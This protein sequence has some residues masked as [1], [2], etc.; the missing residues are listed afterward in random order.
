MVL[1]DSSDKDDAL[2]AVDS[3]DAFGGVASRSNELFLELP[4]KENKLLLKENCLCIFKAGRYPCRRTIA[5]REGH[6]PKACII[7]ITIEVR[8]SPAA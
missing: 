8:A 2:L 6:L 3:I 5:G 7:Y 1:D 4:W